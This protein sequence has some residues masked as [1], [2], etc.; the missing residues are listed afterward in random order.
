MIITFV[1]EG[2]GPELPEVLSGYAADKGDTAW[3]FYKYNDVTWLISDHPITPDDVSSQIHPILTD[4]LKCGAIYIDTS[5]IYYLN[6][7]DS[8]VFADSKILGKVGEE[9]DLEDFLTDLPDM[10]EVIGNIIVAMKENQ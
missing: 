2:R 8:E 1:D 7:V 3:Y 5:G 6:K 4:L 10:G 9:D